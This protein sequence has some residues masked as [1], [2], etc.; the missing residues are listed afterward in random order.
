MITIIP[1]FD[2][3]QRVGRKRKELHRGSESLFSGKKACHMHNI[4]PLF[5]VVGYNLVETTIIPLDP[6]I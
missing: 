6:Y 5:I 4:V 3:Q 2:E 1:R